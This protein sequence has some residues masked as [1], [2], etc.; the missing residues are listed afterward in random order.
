MVGAT[1]PA[2]L[3][4]VRQACPELPLLIPGV[5]AQQADLVA[6]VRAGGDADGWNA[7]ISSSRGVIYASSGCGYAAA[8]RRSAMALRDAINYTLDDMGFGW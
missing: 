7:V 5:G 4:A 3:A 8:A 1:A 6:A 2:R